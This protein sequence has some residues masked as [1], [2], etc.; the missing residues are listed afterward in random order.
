MISLKNWKIFEKPMYKKYHEKNDLV[1]LFCSTGNLLKKRYNSFQETI[2]L[3]F[4]FSNKII[5]F[6]FKDLG[7]SITLWFEDPLHLSVGL[8][9]SSTYC[10]ST[11][12]ST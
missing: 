6:F 7:T 3:Y 1:K 4:Y 11:N 8:C 10:P 5:L 2:P 9:N 12:T